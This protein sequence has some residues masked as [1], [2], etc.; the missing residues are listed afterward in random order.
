VGPLIRDGLGDPISEAVGDVN[1]RHLGV[2]VCGVFDSSI[3]T[4]SGVI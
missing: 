4:M 2:G 1:Q 3:A